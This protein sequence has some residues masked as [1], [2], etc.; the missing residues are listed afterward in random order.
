MVD[1]YFL[2]SADVFH[3]LRIKRWK[4]GIL[5]CPVDKVGRGNEVGAVL[6]HSGDALVV[7]VGTMLDGIDTSFGGPEDGLCTVGVSGNFA[8]EAVRIGDEGLHLFEGVLAGLGIIALGE[9]ATTGG[10]L[11]EIGAVL[12]VFANLMLDGGDAVGYGFAVDVI[13]VGEQV[14]VHVAAGDAECGTR[15]LHVRARDV[16]G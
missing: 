15:D 6:L 4:V 8:A 1:V 10:K 11:N 12:D 3:L 13:L 2:D 16:A 14:L 7:D 9:N 5:L